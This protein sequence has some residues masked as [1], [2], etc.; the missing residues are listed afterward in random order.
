M[1]GFDVDF[2]WG[3]IGVVWMFDGEDSR[4]DL[5]ILWWG[6]ECCVLYYF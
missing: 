5:E 3:V 2:V 4:G 6:I 1:F